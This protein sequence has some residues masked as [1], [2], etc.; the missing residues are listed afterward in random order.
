MP[1]SN[2]PVPID[3]RVRRFSSRGSVYGSIPTPTSIV[4]AAELWNQQLSDTRA[5]LSVAHGKTADRGGRSLEPVLDTFAK[6]RFARP[7]PCLFPRCVCGEA[8]ERVEEAEPPRIPIFGRT[9]PVLGM[10][11]SPDS[12]SRIDARMTALSTPAP[13]TPMP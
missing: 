5:R 13:T 6:R 9:P 3:S 8:H 2:G 12:R 11:V 4:R 10:I 1:P 7:F